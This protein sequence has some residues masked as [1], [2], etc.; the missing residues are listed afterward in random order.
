LRYSISKIFEK[1]GG[2]TAHGQ[3]KERQKRKQQCQQQR[4]GQLKQKG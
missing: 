4:K 2:L 3:Q 1:K